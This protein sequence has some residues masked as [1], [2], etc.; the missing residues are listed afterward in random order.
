MFSTVDDYMR[1]IREEQ[2]ERKFKWPMYK[3]DFFP[4]D[5]IIRDM[6]GQGTIRA[7]LIGRN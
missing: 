2:L 1:A 3:G 4:Y 5:G 7:E 6:Y